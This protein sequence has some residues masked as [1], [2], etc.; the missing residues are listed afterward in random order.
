MKIFRYYKYMLFLLLAFAIKMLEA[1][2]FTHQIQTLRFYIEI[3]YIVIA[4]TVIWEVLKW[5]SGVFDR[6]ITW[7]K[8]PM[9]RFIIQFPLTILVTVILLYIIYI[10]H[11]LFISNKPLFEIFKKSHII[12]AVLIV[13]FS[14]IYFSWQYIYRKWKENNRQIE[15]LKKTGLDPKQDYVLVHS[16]NKSLPI[17]FEDIAQIFIDS[18]VVF[19][20]TFSEQRFLLGKPIEFYGK[21]LPSS[22][23]Y[24]INRQIIANRKYIKSFSNIENRKIEVL[25]SDT[26]TAIISQKN[27]SGFKKW[28]GFN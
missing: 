25:F 13:L 4:I 24:R 9:K 7:E 23:F 22:D 10:P 15:D 18:K 11:S 17:N 21:L 1:R 6:K 28:F 20:R 14:N 2:I 19:L 16:G 5:I 26:S 12:V 27:S 3:F 8:E